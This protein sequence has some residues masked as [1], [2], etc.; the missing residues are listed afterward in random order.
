MNKRSLFFF[1][2]AIFS[3][4]C[5][6]GLQAGYFSE[7]LVE[8]IS[9][10]DDGDFVRVLIVPVSS[11]NPTAFKADLANRYQTR[12]ERH[13]AGIRQLQE[14][15]ENSQAVI[16]N[17]LQ[18]MEQAGQARNIKPFWV[19]NLIETELTIAALR[20]LVSE[21]TID[22]V[23]IYPTIVTIP[24]L[25]SSRLSTSVNGIQANLIAIKADSAWAAG[26]DG[27]GRI[28][29]SFD[30]GVEGDHPALADNYR[31]NKGYP[32]SECWFSSVDSSDFPHTFAS[33][34]SKRSHGTHTTGIMIGHD[35]ASDLVIG[36]APGAD[37]IAA[38]AIDV[39]GVSIFESFQWAADPD[40]DPNTV[41]DIPDVINHSW[42]V[43]GIGCADIFWQV[44]DNSEALGIVNIFAAGNEGS[45]SLTIRNPANRAEDA[46]SNFAVGA[47][48]NTYDSIWFQSSRGPS[49]CDGVSI[50]PNV[51]APGMQIYSSVPGG[52][53]VAQTGTSGAAPH[54]SGA[55]A[56][57]R[58]KNP[59]ATVDEIK[60]ALLNSALDL[61]DPGP[62]NSYG[63]G[64]IDIMEAL[65]Q[66]GPIAEPSLQL[67]ELA[68]PEIYPGD[69]VS[70]DMALKNVGTTAQTV[71]ATFSNAES[72]LTILSGQINFG[73]INPDEIAYGNVTLDLE[74]DPAVESGRFY[75]L[76]MALSGA[77]YDDTTRL[78]FFVGTQGERTYFHHD[79][80]R[81]KFTISNYGAFGFDA[82]S[83][84]P[85]GFEG[86]RLDRD[87][88][89]LYE[90]ALLIGV[91]SLH[92]SDCAKN[93]AQEPDND[94]AVAAGGSIASQSPGPL[95]DQETISFFD[96]RYAERPIGIAVQQKSYGWAND[97]DNTF[98]ILEYVITNNSKVSVNGIR[99]GLYF[100]WD[101]NFYA[102]NHGSF[103][104]E[105]EIG[106][107]CWTG[108]GDSADFRGVKVLN[109]E[110]LTN[111]RIYNNPTEV[112]YSN[113]TEARKYQGLAENSAGTVTTP[114]D[115]SH[116]TAT[117]PFN[118]DV[119]QTDT[120]A[121]AIIG[122]ANWDAFITCAVNAEQKY[123]DLP[124]DIDDDPTAHLPRNFTLR[125][126]FPNPFNPAT[127]ISLVIPQSGQVRID[128]FDILGRRIRTVIDEH[129]LAGEHSILWDGTSDSGEPAASG[130]Y[131]YRVHYNS[132]SLTRKMMLV[133]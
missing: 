83:F 117:G 110:G 100:D 106:Y 48:D 11:H 3:L 112:Y 46:L 7:S 52:G 24:D 60:A 45:S 42:G 107:L 93:I 41:S 51:A 6:S 130:I 105:E 119:Q 73:T 5:V 44:I 61:G 56:I 122:G 57:L 80:G 16:K 113:F 79:T 114:G 127:T 94:F 43:T 29:C 19:A 32:A 124:T 102:Q 101:I 36:V 66:I 128:I 67:A 86:Y 70:L 90:A 126:N 12:V 15:A 95:A 65:R 23:E 14:I 2:I 118:L 9:G 30:T 108:G 33:A 39:P 69:A 31:G 50:K 103:L 62:D 34:L 123:N 84:I 96:D 115:V 37:W 82:V 109:P 71:K 25:V 92:V 131:F 121:F 49:D 20:Q 26:Y 53:Y 13:Q 63:W 4:I 99:V 21:S 76:D 72:G 28:V 87:V 35:D 132:S 10:R 85:L 88:N 17:H 47:L 55:V 75:S 133:K 125:Q 18:D 68:Y 58:Q 104:P 91:D 27:S 111:H 120:A 38:V 77:N 8:Y 98:V 89:D 97:P 81:V 1:M 40:G 59:N 64:R 116:V 54:V 78:N 74:F 129:L 22:R